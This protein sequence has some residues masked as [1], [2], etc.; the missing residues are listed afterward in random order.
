MLNASFPKSI[1]AAV[2][3]PYVAPDSIANRIMVGNES[4]HTGD[5]NRLHPAYGDELWKKLERAGLD[6]K[7]VNELT[8]LEVCA[9]TGFLTYHLLQ[10]CNPNLTV[11]DISSDELKFAQNLIET[12]KLNNNIKW[13]LGDMHTV[14]FEQKF[15]LIIGNSFLHHFYNVPE[16]LRRF[17]NLLKPGGVFI[18]LHEPTPMSIIV[19]GAK[20][21]AWPLAVL[22]PNFV[23]DLARSRFKGEPSSTDLWVF[24][25]KKLR[26]LATQAQFAS[27]DAYAWGLVRPII[28]QSYDLHLSAN[29]LFLSD[30]EINLFTKAVKIDSFLNKFLPKRCFGSLCLAF[31][32]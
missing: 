16:V 17:Y 14:K 12:H 30:D 23:G 22:A 7:S 6:P 21:F 32:K 2:R 24:E 15:D 29:K 4:F 27:M 10:R 1:C 9:G 20:L 5:E 3:S 19:E 8:V 18:S 25:E 11:N 26:A 13:V 28:V 31:R